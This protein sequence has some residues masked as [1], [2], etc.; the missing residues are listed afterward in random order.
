ALHVPKISNQDIPSKKHF[1]YIKAA[2]LT[3]YLT[4]AESFSWDHLKVGKFEVKKYNITSHYNH[5]SWLHSYQHKEIVKVANSIHNS[6]L[7]ALVLKEFQLPKLLDDISK[8]AVKQMNN[9]TDIGDMT[10]NQTMQA[11]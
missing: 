7:K 9:K 6:E 4:P 10:S 5:I 3:Q 8:A 11:I 2:A 1:K